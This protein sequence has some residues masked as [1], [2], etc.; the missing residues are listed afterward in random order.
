MATT[1]AATV[2]LVESQDLVPVRVKEDLQVLFVISAL[3][4]LAR[5]CLVVCS[6]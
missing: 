3:Q 5:L 6:A 1:I 2:S 4:D